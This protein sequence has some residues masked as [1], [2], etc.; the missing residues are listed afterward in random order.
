MLLSIGDDGLG[1]TQ[2]DSGKTGEL[3]GAGRVDINQFAGGKRSGPA[4]GTI[5]LS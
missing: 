2:S 1:Q 5:A 4:H 3:A